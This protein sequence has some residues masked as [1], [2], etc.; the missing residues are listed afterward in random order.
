[1]FEA[2]RNAYTWK[3]LLPKAVS[4]SCIQKPLLFEAISDFCIQKPLLS[5]AISP[6]LTQKNPIVSDNTKYPVEVFIIVSINN[7]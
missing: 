5:E 2:I 6:L 4:D 7:K 3:V 1:M